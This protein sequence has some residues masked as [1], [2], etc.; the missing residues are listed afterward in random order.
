M[1]KL[2]YRSSVQVRLNIVTN[3]LYQ[4]EID[5]SFSVCKE[6]VSYI[7]V[8]HYFLCENKLENLALMKTQA[9]NHS[10]ETF[11]GHSKLHRKRQKSLDIS[12]Q[13][14]KTLGGRQ[15][16]CLM[17]L[18]EPTYSYYDHIN[19]FSG[20]F[21]WSFGTLSIAQQLSFSHQHLRRCHK[22]TT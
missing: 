11:S 7:V 19:L 6:M 21:T 3:S 5:P 12:A 1:D 13:Y 14:L 15:I 10:H 22:F 2:E 20:F 17:I 4:K 16:S 18:W 8:Y 9:N